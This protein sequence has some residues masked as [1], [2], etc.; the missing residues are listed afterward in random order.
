MASK[1]NAA[2]HNDLGVL[3]EKKGELTDALE[4]YRLARTEDPDLILAY[5]NAGNVNVKWRGR[6]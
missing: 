2:Y 5:I 6:G 1:R 4:Q 3:L